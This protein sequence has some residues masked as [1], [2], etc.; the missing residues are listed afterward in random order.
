[1]SATATANQ[2]WAAA[3]VEE[4]YQAILSEAGKAF[5]RDFLLKWVAEHKEGFFLRDEASELDCTLFIPKN[6]SQLYSFDRGDE[7]AMFRIV[8]KK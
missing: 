8:S 4:N 5:D 7:N 2:A 1:M 3:I 6:F